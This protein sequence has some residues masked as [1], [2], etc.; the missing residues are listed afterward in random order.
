[1]QFYIDT[2]YKLK[3]GA[4]PAYGNAKYGTDD[5]N[6]LAFDPD[7]GTAMVRPEGFSKTA[8]F[9]ANFD[10]LEEDV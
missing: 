5:L 8:A 3:D 10:D 6:I 9:W 4:D 1:M 7:D 2:R